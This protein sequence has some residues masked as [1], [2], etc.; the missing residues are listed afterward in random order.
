[1]ENVRAWENSGDGISALSGAVRH[2]FVWQSGDDGIVGAIVTDNISLVNGDAGIRLTGSIA[3][4]NVLVGNVQNGIVVEAGSSAVLVA[5]NT[6]SQGPDD[7]ALVAEQ[8]D[9]A[10]VSYSRNNIRG[11]AGGLAG[12]CNVINGVLQCPPTL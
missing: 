12:D 10:E 1:M 5:E 7:P 3:R 8:P 9:L 2:C 6:I 4:R 11:I